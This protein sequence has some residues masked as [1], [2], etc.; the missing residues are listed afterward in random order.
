MVA[1]DDTNRTTIATQTMLIIDSKLEIKIGVGLNSWPPVILNRG[2]V[3]IPSEVAK[4]LDRKIGENVSIYIDWA[5]PFGEVKAPRA[6]LFAM[7]TAG[8]ENVD[9]NFE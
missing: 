6:H 8:L 4:Y 7:L 9:V 1:A 3:M 2:D 5:K